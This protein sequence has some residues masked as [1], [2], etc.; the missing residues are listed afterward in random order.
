MKN[1][2][3]L[4]TVVLFSLLNTVV[5]QAI[6]T[7][8]GPSDNIIISV[9][10]MQP[11]DI[12]ELTNGDYIL[13]SRFGVNLDCSAALPCIIR[14][15]AG[16][17]PHVQRPNASQNIMDI[18]NSNY[19]TFQ[20]IEFSGGSR[21]IR[22]RE[23]TF[24]TLTNN[25]IHDTGDAAITANDTGSQYDTLTLT[26]NHI[27]H[28]NNT[29]EGMYLG[30]NSNGCQVFNSLIANNY[31][32]HTNGPTVSQGDGIELKEGSWGNIIRDNVIHDTTYP[33][34]LTYSTVGN[35]S[36]NI[37]ERNLMWGCGDHAIQSAA[38]AI[39]RNN[40]I[41]GAAQDGIR[42]QPHQAGVPNNLEIYNNTVFNTTA[43][44]IRL[45]NIAGT[46]TVANNALYSQSGLAIRATGDL[47]NLTVLNNVG[48]G[49]TSGIASGFDNGGNLSDDFI[50][51][52]FTG[53]LPQ[54]VFP[55]T[56]S[57]L[58]NSANTTWNASDDFNLTS[59]TGSLDVGAYKYDANGN[60]GWTL[61][62]NFKPTDIIYS[63]GFE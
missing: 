52:S 24:I 28:T 19:V 56:G 53:D 2:W 17:F 37:I 15:K 23:S 51:A 50:N 6:T 63:N 34:I 58:I 49:G 38:D 46:V 14:A 13:G 3:P 1:T 26:N 8:I 59:R 10:A 41:L 32:H 27:H 62:E 42:S 60:P 4:S 47:T 25:H 54:N 18:E 20:N 7:E 31:I 11:G 43:S 29:G 61:A 55:K 35:G 57:L 21:G 36:A 12:L 44:V 40:I 48:Q 16:H 22:I 39:I 5:V 30:C 9:N 33:C 45:N